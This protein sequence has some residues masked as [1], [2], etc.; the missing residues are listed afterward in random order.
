MKLSVIR[1][2]KKW[3]I[4]LVVVLLLMAIGMIGMMSEPGQT[5]TDMIV[6]VILAMVFAA[7]AVFLFLASYRR[8]AAALDDEQMKKSQLVNAA[9]LDQERKRKAAEDLQ[10]ERNSEK[11]TF[12]GAK[13][14]GNYE[15][16]Y[17]AP[18]NYKAQCMLASLRVGDEI[19]VFVDYDS[20]DHTYVME[21][22]IPLPPKLVNL[23]AYRRVCRLYVY[24]IQ[25]DPSGNRAIEIMAAIS[26]R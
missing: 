25:E 9:A 17:Y 13:Q 22:D 6:D 4:V 7:A 5:S 19:H 18:S 10:A 8:A 26:E 15:L 12:E 1:Y 2:I 16:V 20:N 21:D 11:Y 3:I 24:S 23:Y 14:Y